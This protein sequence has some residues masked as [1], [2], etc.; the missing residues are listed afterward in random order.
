M[1]SGR[2]AGVAVLVGLVAVAAP[3]TAAVRNVPTLDALAAN[4]G[5][6]MEDLRDH[7]GELDYSANTVWTDVRTVRMLETYQRPFFG[8]DPVW[9]G[10]AEKLTNESD[11]QPGDA[12]LL[13]SAYDDTCYH[14][15]IQIFKW[16][17]AN[18]IP[19][20]WELVYRSEAG[21]VEFYRV[22]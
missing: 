13:Y 2:A 7:L 3:V 14:C 20:N 9:T 1:P 17:D 22:T 11:P 18:P 19:D 5:D 8:G 15:R 4:G 12:V 21:T 16:L 6:A 10:K